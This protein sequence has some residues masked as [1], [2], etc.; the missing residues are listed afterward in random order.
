[1]TDEED[2]LL[3]NNYIY[4]CLNVRCGRGINFDVGVEDIDGRVEAES[5]FVPFVLDKVLYFLG[6]VGNFQLEAKV[7]IGEGHERA[8]F[9]AFGALDAQ[10]RFHR[11]VEVG[12]V[13]EKQQ[14][15]VAVVGRRKEKERVALGQVLSDGAF[16]DNHAL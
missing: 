8:E 16:I 11:R 13:E 5:G 2:I 12:V 15:F 1:M 10:P 6:N 14:F 9:C 7:E 4:L 3:M